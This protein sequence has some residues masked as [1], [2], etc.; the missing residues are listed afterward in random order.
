MDNK[1]P[2]LKNAGNIDSC[3]VDGNARF[4]EHCFKKNIPPSQ[5][6]VKELPKA[7]KVSNSLI[8]LHQF[9]SDIKV[10]TLD[11]TLSTNESNCIF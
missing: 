6:L 11:Q 1:Q 5:L 4:L 7:I 8:K 3:I 10:G 9:D 2:L